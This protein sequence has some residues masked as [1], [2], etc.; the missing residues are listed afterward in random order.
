MMLCYSIDAYT[1]IIVNNQPLKRVSKLVEQSIGFIDTQNQ[2]INL[3]EQRDDFHTEKSNL[4]EPIDQN[5]LFNMIPDKQ[6]A[7]YVIRTAQKTIR[8][9]NS[10]SSLIL[11]T[12]LSTYSNYLF[13]LKKIYY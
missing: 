2:K 10:L 12:C 9:E 3:D 8:Q 6:F 1:T 5:Q 13:M 4:H 7:D 11:Y